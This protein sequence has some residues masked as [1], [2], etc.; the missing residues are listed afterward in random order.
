M[1]A[2]YWRRPPTGCGWS[3]TEPSSRST[4][5]STTTAASCSAPAAATGKIAPARDE[6]RQSRADL[7]RAAAEK[8]SELAPL[9]RRIDAFDKTIA[10][11]SRR[12]AEIDAMLADPKLYD[13][14]PARVAALGKERADAAGELARAEDEWLALSGEYEDALGD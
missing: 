6:G 2:I 9:K 11:L 7:R 10:R 1:I 14:E 8:R 13:R 3:P 4:A 5:T 12:I